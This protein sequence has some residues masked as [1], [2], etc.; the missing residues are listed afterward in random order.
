MSEPRIV[1]SHP[2]IMSGEPVF[3]GTR[4]PV[5]ALMDYLEEGDT[6]ESFLD[7]FPPVTREHGDGIPRT[8]RT[9]HR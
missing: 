9:A 1:H 4:V 3:V 8:D 7:A 2:E 6:I 5:R